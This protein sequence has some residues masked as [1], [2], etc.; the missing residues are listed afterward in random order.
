MGDSRAR[1]PNIQAKI[2]QNIDRDVVDMKEIGLE[3]TPTFFVNGKP[4]P[5]F[6]PQQLYDLV[7]AEVKVATT[8]TQ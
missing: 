6:G 1:D 2:T 8:P 7:A 4:L 5:S 3:R